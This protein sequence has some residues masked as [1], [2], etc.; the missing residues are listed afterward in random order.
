M[1]RINLLPLDQRQ[2]KW[3]VNKLLF[4]SSILIVFIFIIIY[5]YSLFEVW[6]LEKGL[7]NA[8][9]QYQAL[10][11]TRILMVNAT[12]KQQQFDKKNNILMVLTKERQS[13]YSIIKHLTAQ[14]SPQIWFTD[15]GKSEKNGI[16]IKGWAKTYPLVAEFMKTME[17][18]QFFTEPVLNSVEKDSVTQATKFDII[19]KPRGI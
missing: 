19:V 18:D 11:P 2:S 15:L 5:G 17:N 1:I 8:R 14:T 12:N 9:N 6:N 4:G 3:P 7:Q 16:Q 13:W 10:E